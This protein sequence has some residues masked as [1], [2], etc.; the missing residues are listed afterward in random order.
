MNRRRLTTLI[1]I[2]LTFALM[3]LLF[4]LVIDAEERRRFL[5]Q[6]EQIHIGFYLLGLGFF[7]LFIVVWTFRW[8][9]LLR[10]ADD[11]TPYSNLLAT[12]LVGNFFALFMPEAVGS[13]VAR[14]TR[15][16]QSTTSASFVSTVL[17]DRVIGL[18]SLTILAGGALL[19]GSN[20]FSDQTATYVIVGV[21]VFFV[22]GWV[23]FFNRRFMDFVFGILFRL[24]LMPRL[25]KPIRSLYEALYSFHNRP[26]V[27]IQALL[28]SLVVQS[29]EIASVVWLGQALGLTTPLPFYFIVMPIVW[30]VITIPISIGGLGMREGVFIAF[31]GQVGVGQPDALAL[32]LL[33]YSFKVVLGVVGGVIWLRLSGSPTPVPE[34]AAAQ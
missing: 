32:S 23:L 29:I 16:M 5:E 25:E 31:L 12:T 33:Y 22:V 14:A 3:F 6:I 10:A 2:V 9:Y 34:P 26:R 7:C 27:L 4:T 19:L 13:D 28:L 24:P 11:H 20:I 18:V 1:R 8:R 17:L 30:L 15:G 21:V